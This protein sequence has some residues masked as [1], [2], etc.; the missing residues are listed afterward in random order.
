MNGRDSRDDH[1]FLWCALLIFVFAVL[2]ALYVAHA[3]DVNRPLLALAEGER[4]LADA[5]KQVLEAGAGRGA[6]SGVC[7]LF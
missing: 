7:A 3:D 2:P 5:K 4:R 6:D 1:L